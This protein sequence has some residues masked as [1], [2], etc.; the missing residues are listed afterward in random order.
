M[1]MLQS[2][3]SASPLVRELEDK[4]RDLDW[5]LAHFAFVANVTAHASACDVVHSPRMSVVSCH[6]SDRPVLAFIGD[7][8]NLLADYTAFLAEPG[9]E[10]DVLVSEEQHAVV[11]EAFDVRSEAVKLQM[12]FEGRAEELVSPQAER[13]DARDLRAMHALAER[14]GYE[15]QAFEDDLLAQG[16]AFGIWEGR[17]LI[18][19]ATTLLTLPGA[20]QI[21]NVVT[22][23]ERR[24]QGYATQAVSAL[25]RAHLAEER[26]VFV[27]VD[28]QNRAA[29]RLF[30]RLGFGTVRRVYALRCRLER[31]VA[32]FSVRQE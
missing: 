28:R 16:P 1:E 13:L 23:P 14:S 8:A 29:I 15:V 32:D 18:S 19:M 4:M 22:L 12:L 30:D 21:G 17:K 5:T 2:L 11:A 6:C 3:G 27:I 25:V 10:V 9:S 7:A 20:A 31:E 26:P 24:R